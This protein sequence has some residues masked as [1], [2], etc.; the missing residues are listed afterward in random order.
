MK[1]IEMEPYV[2]G[3]EFTRTCK[4]PVRCDPE[5]LERALTTL[6]G[7]RDSDKIV[8][9]CEIP[10]DFY[11][12]LPDLEKIVPKSQQEEIYYSIKNH[13]YSPVVPAKCVYYFSTL[14]KKYGSLNLA[15]KA[16]RSRDLNVFFQKGY[17]ADGYSMRD[18]FCTL[19]DREYECFA[20][21]KRRIKHRTFDEVYVEKTDMV[22]LL[23]KDISQALSDRDLERLEVGP[24]GLKIDDFT[25]R[26]LAGH[27][28]AINSIYD[29]R[30]VI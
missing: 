17:L 1:L 14:Y 7:I 23:P 21:H 22:A 18:V 30:D 12:F 13:G 15:L 6:S 20:P 8:S 16:L 25:L 5:I 19:F 28:G 24:N 3:I 2:N 29:L 9:V 26:F 4:E 11:Y 10:R 27:Y